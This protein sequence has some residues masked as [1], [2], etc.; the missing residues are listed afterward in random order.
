[1]YIEKAAVTAVQRNTEDNEENLENN[2][3]KKLIILLIK[4]SVDRQ[5]KLYE[6]YAL[7]E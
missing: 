2:D 3:K 4:Y 5:D 1:M 6:K 7:L